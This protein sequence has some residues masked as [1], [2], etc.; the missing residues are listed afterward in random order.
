M[1][2]PLKIFLGDLTYDTVTLATEAFP[3]NVGYIA[4]Y[5]K[6]RFGDD[7]DIKIF[8]YISKLDEAIKESPPDILGLSN[9]CWS[10]NVSLEMFRMLSQK[11]PHALKIWGGPNFPIDIPSQEEFM[12]K[13]IEIDAYVPTDGETGFSNIIEQVLQLDSLEQIRE[14]ILEKPIEGC[15]TRNRMG[16]MQFSIPTIRIKN[17]DEIPSPYTSRLLDE[18]FDGKLTPMIQTNRGCP[19]HCTFAQMEEMK[20]IK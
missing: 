2:K 8:K 5:C 6:K 13:H 20:W 3:L 17:L 18:F 1:I 9:Y 14:K 11:K 10:H 19:F 15:I 16:E 7:V 12:K 4:S